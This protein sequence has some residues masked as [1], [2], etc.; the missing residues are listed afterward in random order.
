MIDDLLCPLQEAT[1]V[2]L[3]GA[4]A[5][6]LARLM[7]VT[8]DAG[9]IA[10]HV[11]AGFAIDYEVVA[12]A[13]ESTRRMRSLAE[14]ICDRLPARFALRSSVLGEDGPNASF[15]GMHL[16]RLNVGSDVAQVSNAIRAIFESASRDTVMNYRARHG[17]TGRVH[18]AIIA[19]TMVC[20]R[21]AGVMFT[22]GDHSAYVIEAARGLGEAVVQ[23]IV[24][25]DH[26][27][28]DA[29]GTCHTKQLGEQRVMITEAPEGGVHEVK[30]DT[31]T[32]PLLDSRWRYSMYEAA[33]RCQEI[34]GPRLDIEWA[35]ES[36]RFWILQ[37]RPTT[38]HGN[39]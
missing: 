15:A 30:I 21:L 20:S 39:G 26:Y 28:M 19:Q 2:A 8:G 1:D 37:V 36:G 6:N 23:G 5:A 10:L 11:P 7:N 12:I 31:H 4:K 17:I 33:R 9:A 25:P 14:E 24:D 16:T 27:R 22:G 35:I 38:G 32:E 13:C 29:A 3:Y 34:F 18:V